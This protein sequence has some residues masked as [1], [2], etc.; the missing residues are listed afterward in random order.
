M[1]AQRIVLV[2]SLS[3][4]SILFMSISCYGQ[5]GGNIAPLATLGGSGRDLRAAVDG[6][7]Q[8]DGNGEWIGG[9]PNAWYGWIVI[10]GVPTGLSNLQEYRPATS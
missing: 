5:A 3:L 1:K 9:S 4:I 10:Q 7:K 2:L 8:R 6:L